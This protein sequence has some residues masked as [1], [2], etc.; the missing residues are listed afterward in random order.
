MITLIVSWGELPLKAA[1]DPLDSK[2]KVNLIEALMKRLAPG[3][4]P[5]ITS[6]P[7]QQFM[8]NAKLEQ[9]VRTHVRSMDTIRRLFR[10]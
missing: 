3:L 8:D 5:D 7:P 6:I 4:P 2:R 10:T 9:L 1:L